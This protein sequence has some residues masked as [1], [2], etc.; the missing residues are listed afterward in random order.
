MV[1]LCRC[2]K[3]HPSA[4]FVSLGI[5]P[6]PPRPPLSSVTVFRNIFEEICYV[7]LEGRKVRLNYSWAHGSI[8]A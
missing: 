6:L 5:T 7:I 2:Q 3:T 8:S 4:A 1:E